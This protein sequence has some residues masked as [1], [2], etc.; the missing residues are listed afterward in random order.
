MALGFLFALWSAACLGGLAVSPR[1]PIDLYRRLPATLVLLGS[2]MELLSPLFTP[3][4]THPLYGFVW[5]LAGACGLAWG[6]FRGGG[7][8]A[9]HRA[10]HLACGPLFDRSRELAV[11]CGAGIRTRVYVTG[12]PPRDAYEVHLSLAEVRSLSTREIDA[13]L[14]R[15]FCQL[16]VDGSYEWQLL[17]V[18][19]AAAAC[20]FALYHLGCLKS[21][22]PRLKPRA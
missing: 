20:A 2:A 19:A 13:L 1:S 12:E 14:V 5:V 3:I 15:Q 11:K 4:S 22:R 8:R 6:A 21:S 18:S 17:S 10:G 16:I 9:G 7:S